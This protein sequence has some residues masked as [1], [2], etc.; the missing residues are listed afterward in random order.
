[1]LRASPTVLVLALLLLASLAPPGAASVAVPP[2]PDP[3]PALPAAPAL[4]PA[5]LLPRVDP[6]E[7][8][9]LGGFVDDPFDPSEGEWRRAADGY[10]HTWPVDDRFAGVFGRLGPRGEA[11][12]EIAVESFREGVRVYPHD[13]IVETAESAALIDGAG[14]PAER[15][16]VMAALLA[17]V[18]LGPTTL[19][20]HPVPGE[21]L[22]ASDPEDRT[23]FVWHTLREAAGTRV[24]LGYAVTS[25]A[26]HAGD[27]ARDGASCTR[28]QIDL[29]AREGDAPPQRLGGL[30]VIERYAGKRADDGSVRSEEATLE[31]GLRAAGVDVPLAYVSTSDARAGHPEGA[32]SASRYALTVGASA[33]G[34]RPILGARVETEQGAPPRRFDE[35]LAVGVHGADGEFVPVLGVHAFFARTTPTEWLDSLVNEC[36]E[37]EG[38]PGEDGST[39]R[40]D[41][42]VDAGTFV[43]GAFTPLVGVTHDD[44]LAHVRGSIPTGI[45]ARHASQ[46]LV[47]AGPWLLGTYQ[48]TV[49]LTLD[50]DR[51]FGVDTAEPAVG[52]SLMASAGA[53]AAGRYVPVAGARW[54]VEATEDGARREVYQ[55]GTFAGDY[56]AFVPIAEARATSQVGYWRTLLGRGAGDRALDAGVVAPGVGFVPVAGVHSH[57]NAHGHGEH[58]V[59]AWVAGSFVPLAT[60]CFTHEDG[61]AQIN[62]VLV[63]GA[64]VPGGPWLGAVHV[65]LGDP[66]FSGEPLVRRQAVR[67]LDSCGEF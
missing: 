37:P 24:W 3:D 23:I 55:A 60:A 9:S 28:V 26:A 30:Y 14:V 48:P 31:A 64:G 15:A 40:G 36:E 67:P 58:T 46:S 63:V 16:L 5:G 57:D 11:V 52:R 61:D 39:C 56:S 53:F 50:G 19:G 34:G 25:R 27:A 51:E 45:V 6:S 33:A 49:A 22:H 62:R 59:G 8:G 13:V 7:G 21:E 29:V 1:M 66:V 10:R 4:P 43:G 35:M 47:T 18:A 32:P 54:T 12:P 65:E 17:G 38:G 2:C 20:A 42:T 44:A 41:F